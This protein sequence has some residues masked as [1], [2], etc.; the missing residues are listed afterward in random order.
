MVKK[1]VAKR[2]HYVTYG[3]LATM[4][5]AALVWAIDKGR[6]STE[7]QVARAGMLLRVWR[8]DD[9]TRVTVQRQ[10]T[11]IELV[12]EGDGWRMTSPRVARAEF[13][14]VTALLNAIGGARSERAV[15]APSAADRATFGLD[16]P[17]AVVEVAMKGVTIKVT[18]GASVTGGVNQTTGAPDYYVE[19]APYADQ[20]G[21]VY[22]VGADLNAA[23]DRGPDAYREPSLLS[24]SVSTAWQRIEL[25]HTRGKL[26]LERGPHMEWRITA[27][28]DGAP[29]RADA[30]VADGLFAAL[31]GLRADPFVDDS[32]H[33]DTKLGGT[34]AVTT[35]DGGHVAFAFGGPCP[36]ALDGGPPTTLVLAQLTAPETLTGCVAPVVVDRVAVESSKYVDTHAFGLLFGTESAKISE[37]EAVSIETMGSGGKKVVDLERR[38]GGFH[39]RAPSDEQ[40][41]KETSDRFLRAVASVRGI[42]ISPP[43]PLEKIGLAAPATKVM[44]RRRVSGLTIGENDAQASTTEWSQLLEVGT[45]VEEAGATAAAPKD[46]WIYLR[47]LDDGAVIRVTPEEAQSLGAAAAL[48]LRSPNL[49]DLAADSIDRVSTISTLPGVVPYEL[50]RSKLVA[51]VN[52][53]ADAASVGDLTRNLATL[54]CTRWA[55]DRDDGTFGFA[56]PSATIAVH[57]SVGKLPDGGAPEESFVLELGGETTDGGIY[58]RVK[59]RDAVC[60]LP[61]AK[62][63]AILQVPVFR[64][65]MGLDPTETPRIVVSHPPAT[66]HALAFDGKSWRDGGDAGTAS[67]DLA[68]RKLADLVVALRAERLVH[69]GKADDAEGFASPTLIIE[70]LDLGGKSKKRV[71]VGAPSK[72]D[73]ALVYYARVDTLDA[74]YVILRDDVD[75]MLTSL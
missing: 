71:V 25:A 59:G 53:G 60:V 8:A 21:G 29:V 24:S 34:L 50:D 65:V 35:K 42:W 40:I 44:L 46:K 51:P 10:G 38:D 19:I 41:D 49:V 26:T 66:G 2:S 48:T 17:R 16:S 74:T 15:G 31:G 5:A 1:A 36:L 33:P 23:M 72:L 4:G 27:G 13:L 68:A 54:T 30:D 56:A 47:R 61:Y 64:A 39:L 14:A 18:L 52:L 28:V 69:L 22:V 20:K 45:P 43:P 57:R 70:G 11:R 9:I 7:E 37:I 73:G 63:K 75:K 6:P 3:L 62:A 12:R 32:N 67:A 58:A 55:A